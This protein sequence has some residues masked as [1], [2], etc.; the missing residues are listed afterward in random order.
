LIKLLEN[1]S[2]CKTSVSLACV[3]THMSYYHSLR[4]SVADWLEQLGLG[5]QLVR[6]SGS[7]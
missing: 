5:S 3:G 1:K 2:H 7:W 4:G 6:V